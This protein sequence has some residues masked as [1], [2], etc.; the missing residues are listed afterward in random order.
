MGP[1]DALVQLAGVVAS[2]APGEAV[3]YIRASGTMPFGERGIVLAVQGS[4]CEV[5][6]EREGFCSKGRAMI[7]LSSSPALRLDAPP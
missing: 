4:R 5:L 1:S 6:F 7:S 2:H 3:V